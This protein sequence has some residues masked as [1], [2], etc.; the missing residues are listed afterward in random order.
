MYDLQEPTC[1]KLH[2]RSAT[3]KHAMDYNRFDQDLSII[4]YYRLQNKC[5]ACTCSGFYMFN[6]EVYTYIWYKFNMKGKIFFFFFSFTYRTSPAASMKLVVFFGSSYNFL[7]SGVAVCHCAIR[8]GWCLLHLWRTS[9]VVWSSSSQGH[10][11][12]RNDF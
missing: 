3:S 5:K 6:S 10:V 1:L 9:S 2:H 12:G 8:S 11:G 4:D 7:W